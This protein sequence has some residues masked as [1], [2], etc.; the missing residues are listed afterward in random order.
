VRS[1]SASN[2]VP[3][4]W[5]TAARQDVGARLELVGLGDERLE[6]GIRELAQARED[7]LDVLARLLLGEHELEVEHERG[8]ARQRVHG[9]LSGGASETTS[10]AYV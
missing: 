1:S 10:A 8:P 3:H 6:A 5:L 9:H 4:T 7:P 2:E